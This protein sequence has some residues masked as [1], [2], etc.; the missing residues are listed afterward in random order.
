MIYIILH[1]LYLLETIFSAI[2]PTTNGYLLVKI[3]GM[4][5]EINGGFIWIYGEHM[6]VSWEILDDTWASMKIWKYTFFLKLAL[7]QKMLP[8]QNCSL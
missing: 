6:G 1:H 3:V 7:S 5:W 8:A 4:P 2:Q